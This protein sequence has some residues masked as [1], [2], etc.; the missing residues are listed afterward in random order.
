MRARR[1]EILDFQVRH[2]AFDGYVISACGA[3]ARPCIDGFFGEISILGLFSTLKT[4]VTSY[5]D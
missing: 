5:I 2:S 1:Y 3:H 4:F